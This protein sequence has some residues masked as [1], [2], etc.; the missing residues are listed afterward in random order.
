MTDPMPL[1]VAARLCFPHGGATKRTLLDAIR[2]GA[3]GF[4]RVGNRYLTTVADIEAWRKQCRDEARGR[5]STSTPA[6]AA[7]PSTSSGMDRIALAQAAA[8][9]MS[10]ELTRP[11]RTISPGPSGPTPANV[12]CL[13]SHARKS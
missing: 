1:D 8:L 11:S 7:R 6:R 13:K 2:K 4:E 9:A 3:L 10:R 5:V 12:T